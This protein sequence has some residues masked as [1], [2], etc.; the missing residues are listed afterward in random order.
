MITFVGETETE[1][2][3]IEAAQC[4]MRHLPNTV[5]VLRADRT[6]VTNAPHNHVARNLDL[7]CCS[8]T[9]PVKLVY[10]L[11]IP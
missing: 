10:R 8:L 6:E 9:S 3:R 1:Q 7:C 2:F 4:G 5:C 11:L